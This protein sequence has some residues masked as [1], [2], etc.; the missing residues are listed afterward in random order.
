MPTSWGKKEQVKMEDKK[1]KHA[2][3]FIEVIEGDTNSENAKKSME[4]I[5]SK[6]ESAKKKVKKMESFGF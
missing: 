3:M 4:D 2:E 1:K 6:L 5:L